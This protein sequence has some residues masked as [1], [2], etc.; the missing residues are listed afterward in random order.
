MRS[1]FKPMARTTGQRLGYDG[2]SHET[3]SYSNYHLAPRCWKSGCGSGGYAVHLAKRIG[4][5]VVGLD[6]NAGVRNAK[7]LAEE[8][9]GSAPA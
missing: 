4:C 6:I 3:E 5:Q 9:Q 8:R 7:A 1:R 2:E